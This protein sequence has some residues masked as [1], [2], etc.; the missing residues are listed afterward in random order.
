MSSSIKTT[1]TSTS[2][3]DCVLRCGV[4]PASCLLPTG[5]VPGGAGAYAGEDSS[6]IDGFGGPTYGQAVDGIFAQQDG[7]DTDQ[8]FVTGLDLATG[9]IGQLSRQQFANFNVATTKDGSFADASDVMKF[10]SYGPA[11]YR[12]AAVDLRTGQDFQEGAR[13]RRAQAGAQAGAQAEAAKQAIEKQ[14]Q[15]TKDV[16]TAVATDTH[17][18]CQSSEDPH[19]CHLQAILTELKQLEAMLELVGEAGK[20]RNAAALSDAAVEKVQEH[21]ANGVPAQAA[22]ADVAAKVAVAAES[23]KDGSVNQ[24]APLQCLTLNC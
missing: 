2:V 24:F 18:T 12:N 23:A 20:A 14:I 21:L 17:S 16:S 13:R 22:I 8:A 10:A 6:H 15:T 9:R 19:I 11:A 4:D 7:F 1:Q 3:A 5:Q